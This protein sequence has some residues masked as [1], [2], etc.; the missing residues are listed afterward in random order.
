MA[1][2]G[3]KTSGAATFAIMD[4]CCHARLSHVMPD[5]SCNELHPISGFTVESMLDVHRLTP[6]Q[7]RISLPHAM[8]QAMLA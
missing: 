7:P 4:K 8:L 3:P 2:S 6:R 5:A 1:T